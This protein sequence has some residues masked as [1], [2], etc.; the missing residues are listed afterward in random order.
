MSARSLVLTS[1]S[2]SSSPFELVR[3]G[4]G[5]RGNIGPR[6]AWPDHRGPAV[7]T[8][9]LVGPMDLFR[10]GRLPG[11]SEPAVVTLLVLA[12]LAANAAGALVPL[13]T[14]TDGPTVVATI[15]EEP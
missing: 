7:V 1:P 5:P 6:I 8:L 4:C 3:K 14:A 12:L 2:S 11:R 9:L 10:H 15:I 13:C